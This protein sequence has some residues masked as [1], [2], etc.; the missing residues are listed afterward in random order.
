MIINRPNPRVEDDIV[1]NGSVPGNL[2]IYNTKVFDRIQAIGAENKFIIDAR[3]C[4]F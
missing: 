3:V 4:V 1:I 2:R